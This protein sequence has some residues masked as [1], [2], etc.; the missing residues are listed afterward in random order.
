MTLGFFTGKRISNGKS[1]SGKGR[2]TTARIDIIQSCDGLALRKN[3]RKIKK[4]KG[5]MV[6]LDHY[7]KN[8][9]P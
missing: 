4:M 9:T 6:I 1:I 8:F 5:V 3:I 2:L 7:Y